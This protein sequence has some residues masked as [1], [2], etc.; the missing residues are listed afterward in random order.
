MADWVDDYYDFLKDPVKLK[1]SA[2]LRPGQVLLSKYEWEEMLA[3][4]RKFFSYVDK[5]PE[6]PNG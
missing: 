4:D 5:K 1:A 3:Y 6:T 2:K